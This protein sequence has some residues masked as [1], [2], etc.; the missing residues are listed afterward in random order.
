[1]D[2]EIS[3]DEA[4]AWLRSD[5]FHQAL[6]ESDK[7]SGAK[8]QL[9]RDLGRRFFT[10]WQ[11]RRNVRS[12][13]VAVRFA[14]EALDKLPAGHAAVTKYANTLVFYAQT[15]AIAIRG[16]ESTEEYISAIQASI[17]ATSRE[18]LAHHHSVQRLACAYW[19]RFELSKSDEDLEK[20]IHYI[21]GLIDA[22]YNI[23]PETELVLGEAFYN[24]FSRTK[25]TE[26]IEKA[27]DLLEKALKSPEAGRPVRHSLLQ[28]LVQYSA[29]RLHHTRKKPDLTRLISNANFAIPEL[30]QS[31]SKERIEFL[32]SRAETTRELLEQRPLLDSIFKEVGD[33]KLDDKNGPKPIGK[34][35]V[36]KVLY[37]RFI[38]G[39][40]E[41]RTL[42]VTPGKPDEEIVCKLHAVALADEIDYEVRH[43]F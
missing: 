2:D 11:S 36:P 17:D 37:D 8:A 1:M 29:D 34:T 14:E 18:G 43:I 24:R 42:E 6:D 16:P 41:I 26:D 9:L 33:L 27:V 38:I 7:D 19:A 12:L 3:P 28:K 10:D 4:L 5:D 30:S 35:Y 23:L 15:K 25:T 20:V 31:E 40:A 21:S 32:L 13:N 22:H 39:L